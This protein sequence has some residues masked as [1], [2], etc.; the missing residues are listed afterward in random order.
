MRKRREVVHE[1]LY[2]VPLS[3]R[4]GQPVEVFYRPEATM[5]RGRPEIWLRSA[6]NRLG[7]AACNAAGGALRPVVLRLTPCLHGGLGFY[8][9]TVQV[10][11]CVGVCSDACQGFASVEALGGNNGGRLRGVCIGT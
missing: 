1:F 3:P 6:W 5:L 10:C 11:V 4:A 9:A 2:T 8:K 7:A